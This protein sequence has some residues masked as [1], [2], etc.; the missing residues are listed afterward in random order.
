MPMTPSPA[1]MYSHHRRPVRRPHSPT[2]G[3]SIDVLIVCMAASPLDSSVLPDRVGAHLYRPHHGI[4]EAP[5]GISH[6]AHQRGRGATVLRAYALTGHP[7]V[8]TV[9]LP[10]IDRT[11]DAGEETIDSIRV[12]FEPAADAKSGHQLT[13]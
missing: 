5:G 11:V 10:R 9:R 13:I 7:D 3:P 1:A 12:S 4:P 2:H 6:E 8:Q